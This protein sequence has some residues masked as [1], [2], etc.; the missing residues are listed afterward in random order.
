MHTSTT[1]T[2]SRPRLMSFTQSGEH[3]DQHSHYGAYVWQDVCSLMCSICGEHTDQHS[4]YGAYVWQDVCSLMC[5]ICGEHTDQHSHYGAYVWQDVCSLMCSICGEHTDQH[6]HYG[7]YVW[8]DVCS[9][10]DVYLSFC[11]TWKH[12]KHFS[13]QRTGELLWA[14]TRSGHFPKHI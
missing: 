1:V 13:L 2:T 7:T 11:V 4:H 12:C 14:D 3:T 5:S 8:Q 6:S 9:H 10:G